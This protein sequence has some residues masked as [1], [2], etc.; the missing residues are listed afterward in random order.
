MP[1]T[2]PCQKEACAIQDCLGKNNY[3][4]SKCEQAIQ[5]L[6]QC[7]EQLLDSGGSSPCC[8]QRKYGKE[9]RHKEQ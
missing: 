1:P 7:C 5:A 3:Q 6:R 2:P 4:E 8:P 9:A